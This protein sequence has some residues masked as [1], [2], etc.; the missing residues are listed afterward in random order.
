MRLKQLEGRDNK[1]ARRVLELLAKPHD[2]LVTI[3]IGNTL[4]NIAASSVLAQIFYVSFGEKGI[5]YSIISSDDK[6]IVKNMES[7]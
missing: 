4:V 7:Y 2:L 1:A 6:Y 3:L 5:I